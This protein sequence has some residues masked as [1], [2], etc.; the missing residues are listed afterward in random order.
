MSY[1]KFS[2]GFM[3]QIIFI[4]FLTLF[5]IGSCSVQ[6]SSSVESREVTQ[7]EITNQKSDVK[8]QPVLVELFT[9]EGCSSCPPADRTLAKLSNEQPVENAEIV[10]LAYHVDY[11]DYLGWKDRFSSPRYSQRQTV[12]A[13]SFGLNST[14]TPQMVV[15]GK[16]EFVGSKYAEAIKQIGKAS[17]DK[18]AAVKIIVKEELLNP[19]LQID[20]S[21]LE[22]NEDAEVWLAVTE[23]NLQTDVRRGENKGR[24]LSHVSVVRNLQEIG[25][26]LMKEKGFT[27]EKSVKLD[28]NWNRENLSFV[29]FVQNKISRRIVA[30]GK[31]RIN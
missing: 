5:G 21:G 8:K 1:Q 6:S 9:S 15:D 10:T 29:V 28:S 27:V 20:I 12:Y 19:V 22:I 18:K 24:K 2:R 16:Y 26:I 14:Y 17:K 31:V 30:V 11:W 7:T 3:K 23:D 4:G 13:L 25:S